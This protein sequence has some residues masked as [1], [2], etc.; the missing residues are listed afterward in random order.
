MFLGNFINNYFIF[1]AYDYRNDKLVSKRVTFRPRNESEK[2]KENDNSAR[3]PVKYTDNFAINEH[4]HEH[5][6]TGISIFR[7]FIYDYDPSLEEHFLLGL[8]LNGL[9]KYKVDEL[10]FG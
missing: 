4:L 7:Y 2:N 1:T 6:K 8:S 9:F 5:E 10:N 3:S